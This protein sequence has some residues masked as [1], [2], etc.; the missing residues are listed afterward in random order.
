MSIKFGTGGF[1]AIMGEDFTKLNVQKIAQAICN[2]IKQDNL[3]GQVFVG[4]DNRFM[5][6]QYAEWA[7]EV[8]AGNKVNVKLMKKASITPVVNY[9]AKKH[10]LDFSIAITASHNPY[11]YNGVK[12]FTNHGRDATPTQTK[13]LEQL[14]EGL[15]EQDIVVLPIKQAVSVSRVEYVDVEDE[16]LASLL[17]LVDIKHTPSVCFD[18][19]FGSSAC[20][21]EKLIEKLP[22]KN[23]KV[24]NGSRDAFF[25]FSM[26][27]PT[28][29]TVG[30]LHQMVQSGQ[31]ELGFALDGDGDRLAVIDRHGNFV[32]NNDLMAC[33]YYFM[34]QYAGVN[35]DIVKTI[36]TSNL[37][38]ALANKFGHSCHTVNVG[39]KFVSEKILQTNAILGG[40]SSGGLAIPQH[41]MAK[42][43]LLSIV[44]VLQMLSTINKPIDE[45]IKEV[46]DFAEFHMICFEKQYSYDPDKKQQIMNLLFEQKALPEVAGKQV[47]KTEY[48]D[49]I[50]VHYTDG[51]WTL[52]RFSGTEPVIRIYCEEPNQHTYNQTLTAWEEFLGL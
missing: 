29:N 5:S 32:D 8:F 50:K 35:G 42:D 21:L 14:C 18:A 27:S 44:L 26:P 15:T 49:Y 19:M 31:Y 16:Y 45:I 41:V 34:N 43:G 22:I 33:L 48:E 13:R 7:A 47:A 9:Y 40:E 20:L 37:L 23:A 11:L 12:V 24:L 6:E 10:Q 30:T 4:Y 51:S 28:P 39:F 25:A 38:D 3:K 46:R 52:V 17:K 36:S 1:R 2:V